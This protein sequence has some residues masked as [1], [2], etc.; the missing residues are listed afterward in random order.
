LS[1]SAGGTSSASRNA[2]CTSSTDGATGALTAADRKAIFDTAGDAATLRGLETARQ[3]LEREWEP[4]LS[5]SGLVRQESRLNPFPE[6][7]MIGF[8]LT[9]IAAF[10]VLA[11]VQAPILAWT[12]AGALLAWYLSALAGL[13]AAGN[14]VLWAAF[15][16]FALVLNVPVLR[17]LAFSN[18][19]LAVY[20]KILPDMSQTEKEAI[21]AGTVWWD[22]DL[23]SGKPDWD[24]LL[25]VPAGVVIA[26]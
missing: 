3:S 16:A 1:T 4:V 15:G 24:K 9:C 2:S 14:T 5:P 10:F 25:A 20:R 11:Y 17:R 13:G 7:T 12:A 6:D 8:I 19:V 18:R 22:G 21:D 26:H 23:F